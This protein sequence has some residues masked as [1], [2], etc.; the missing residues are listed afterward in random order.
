M[1]HVGNVLP[2][3]TTGQRGTSIIDA[4]QIVCEGG[5][6]SPWRR[7]VWRASDIRSGALFTKSRAGFLVL[8]AMGWALAGGLGAKRLCHRP[9]TPP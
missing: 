5:V 9:T 8:C 2:M 4:K 7:K 1:G 6:L 3:G